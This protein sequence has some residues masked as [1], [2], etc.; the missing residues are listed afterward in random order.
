MTVV[1]G[2]YAAVGVC[3]W[4]A[5]RARPESAPANSLGS[6]ARTP[7]EMSDSAASYFF[8]AACI[9]RDFIVLP[10]SRLNE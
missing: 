2:E 8:A 3:P 1:F 6:H 9:I 5:A 10:H 7:A 4:F